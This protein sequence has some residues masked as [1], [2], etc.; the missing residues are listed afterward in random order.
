MI[1][2]KMV[3]DEEEGSGKISQR[4]IWSKPLADVPIYWNANVQLLLRYACGV[5]NDTTTKKVLQAI[6]ASFLNS[7][8][9]RAFNYV[10]MPALFLS[11]T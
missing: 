7:K 10:C 8:E 3:D 2:D 11:I 6:F 5:I 9:K 4:H 1:T